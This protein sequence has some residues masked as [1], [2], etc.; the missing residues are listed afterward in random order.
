MRKLSFPT[1]SAVLLAAGTLL[2]LP[3]AGA[4]AE[5]KASFAK[6]WATSHEFTIAVA[7]AM[8]ADGYSY[9]P[10]STVEPRER[11]FAGLLIHIGES[12]ANFVGKIAG[13][14]ASAP[15]PPSAG[16]TD[17]EAIVQY[18]N[19]VYEFTSK[20]IDAVTDEQLKKM[21]GPPGRLIPGQEALQAIYTHE[22]H[23]RGQC[24]VYL[25]LKNVKPP[26]YRF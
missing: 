25:R 2:V 24:E 6:R 18:L 7:Q 20:A 8:P 12:D 4:N 26:D 1:E 5:W 21:V 19:D 16:S 10:P 15:K 9:V 11:T 14:E 23:T 22:A 13:L 3:L 17:K